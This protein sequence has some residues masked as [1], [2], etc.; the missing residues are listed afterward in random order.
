MTTPPFMPTPFL[1]IVITVIFRAG[2]VNLAVG[3][4]GAIAGKAELVGALAWDALFR[5]AGGESRIRDM[6]MGGGDA[7]ES[8]G[9]FNKDGAWEEAGGDGTTIGPEGEGE[10]AGERGVVPKGG[11]SDGCG[12]GG[13]DKFTDGGGAAGGDGGGTDERGERNG[14]GKKREVGG[15]DNGGG[16]D[17]G[18]EGGER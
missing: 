14:E 18:R 7:T 6:V 15:V 11:E 3:F 2:V 4:S 17:W 1:D 5:E 10:R 12:E 9:R 16:D 8:G 13:C